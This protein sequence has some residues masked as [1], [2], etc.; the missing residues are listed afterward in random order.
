MSKGSNFHGMNLELY[1]KVFPLL[2]FPNRRASL[3]LAWENSY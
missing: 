1:G 3:E 2:I